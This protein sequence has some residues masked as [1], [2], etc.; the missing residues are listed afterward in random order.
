M[1][2]LVLFLIEKWRSVPTDW[3]VMVTVGI[4]G[5]LLMFSAF[6]ISRQRENLAS[7]SLNLGSLVVHYAGYGLGAGQYR[8]VTG[9]V[10]GFIKNGKIHMR[11][12]PESLQCDPYRGQL[13][14]L[15]VIYSHGNI[16][17]GKK[18][19]KDEQLLELP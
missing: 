11:V 2:S 17:G 18:R 1:S 8:D 5:F 12:G 4:V 3:L 7:S 16:E 19:I 14:H 6:R 10:K 15:L 13:K 9:Q